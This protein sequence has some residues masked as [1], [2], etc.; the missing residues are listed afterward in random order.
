[1][2]PK[3]RVL[4]VGRTRYRLP[5]PDWLRK[6][7][8]AI[9]EELEFR[10]LGAAEDGE[11]GDERFELVEP[12]TPRAL[13]GAAFYASL[14]FRIRAN[15]ER[16]RPQ[17]IVAEN[18]HVAAAALLARALVRGERPRVIA[19]VH[20]D[21]RTAT[22]LYGSPRRKLLSPLADGLAGLALRR[23][24]AVRALSGFTAAVAERTTGRAVDAAFPTYSDLALFAEPEP[25]RLPERPSA[26]FVGV[27]EPYKNVDALAAAWRRVVLEVAD[28]R[29]VVVG[30]GS[31]RAAVA[32]LVAEH[33]QRTGWIASLPPHEVARRMDESWVFV[34]P[35]RHEGLGRVVIESFARGRGVVASREGGILD[36]VRDDV[37]GLLIDPEDTDSLAG[38]LVRVLSDRSLA[39]RLGAAARERYAEWHSTPEEFARRMRELVDATLAR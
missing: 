33:P 16:F 31:R 5:L 38:A 17:A 7:W 10:V 23:A 4:F 22:R 32:E 35:S 6:K 9:G 36:L 1:M 14:P 24:D 27:L 13:D 30:K 15:I 8:D 26:L 34:L 25:L 11:R 39:E 21:W 12:L 20:G 37:E 3:P 19:E 18:P 28:A 2:T 29:L